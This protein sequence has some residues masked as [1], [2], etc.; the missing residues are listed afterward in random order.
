METTAIARTVQP[1]DCDDITATA[2]TVLTTAKVR[3]RQ[4]LSGLIHE[5]ERAV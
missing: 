4:A 5:Y 2:A 1:P 3:R